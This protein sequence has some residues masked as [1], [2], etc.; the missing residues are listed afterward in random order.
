MDAGQNA[1][2]NPALET[3]EKRLE[4]LTRA[5]DNNQLDENGRKELADLEKRVQKNR[6]NR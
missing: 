2:P 5:R 4:E 6:D 1:N 3:D